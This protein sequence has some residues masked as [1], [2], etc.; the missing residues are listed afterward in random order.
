MKT[1][2]NLIGRSLTIAKRLT[3]CDIKCDGQEIIYKNEMK[4]DLI[5]NTTATIKQKEKKSQ[6]VKREK[7]PMITKWSLLS[8]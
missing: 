5:M 1:S 6:L 8:H 2:T 4:L 7:H 3:K